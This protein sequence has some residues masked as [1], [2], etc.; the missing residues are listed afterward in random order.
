M[1][2]DPLGTTSAEVTDDGIVVQVPNRQIARL[3]AL[4][5]SVDRKNRQRVQRRRN[6]RR[7]RRMNRS[8]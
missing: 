6:Q 4:G 3:I 5:V 2:P 8:N 7:S 1:T